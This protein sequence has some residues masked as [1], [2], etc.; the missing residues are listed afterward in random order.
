MNKQGAVASIIIWSVIA[1]A[2]VA[3]LVISILFGTHFQFFNQ[4]GIGESHVIY[5]NN[6]NSSEFN[7]VQISWHA[8]HV[9][10]RPTEDDQMQLTQRSN[11]DV[12]ELSCSVSGGRLMIDENSSIGFFFFGFGNRSSDLELYLPKKQY[13][14]FELKMT[15]G[16]TDM[17]GV[18]ADKM[19]FDLTSGD[20]RA[21]TLQTKSLDVHTTS[22][23]I[24]LDSVQA[25]SVTAEA[26]SGKITVS[27]SLSAIKSK[28][29]SGAVTM[30]TDVVPSA[31]DADLTS[32]NIKI[33][34]PDND[35]FTL[36]CKKT[37]GSLN[38]DFDLSNS[39]N[40]N[41]NT[42]RYLSG[43]SS[44]LRY[45]AEITSGNFSLMKK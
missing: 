40:D 21:D 29:T 24:A 10:I 32:G 11:Y 33:T 1:A 43:G 19:S 39:I 28:T 16:S 3:V 31:L 13:E 35:G 36:A 8:G 25:D 37:S 7:S 34:I 14:E 26:T 2:L 4:F 6:I 23:T 9:Q 12:S 44:N 5:Q 15:S 45:T 42:Y 17:N 18:S 27:G 20:I 30:A 22:G 38:S 41:K